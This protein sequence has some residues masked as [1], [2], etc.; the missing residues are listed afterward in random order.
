MAHKDAVELHTGGF[1]NLSDIGMSL[2]MTP[3]QQCD[4]W[5]VGQ[6]PCESHASIAIGHIDV[7]NCRYHWIIM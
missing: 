5:V 2:V 1:E 4:L 6:E 3:D 7:I